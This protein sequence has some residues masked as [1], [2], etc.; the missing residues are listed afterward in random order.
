M[1]TLIAYKWTCMFW[2]GVNHRAHVAWEDMSWQQFQGEVGRSW[3]VLEINGGS[4][5][6]SG[7]DIIL[8]I[9]IEKPDA[10]GQMSF[11]FFFLCGRPLWSLMSWLVL[12]SFL[13]WLFAFN[14]LTGYKQT[15]GMAGVSANTQPH[16]SSVSVCPSVTA[17]IRVSQEVTTSVYC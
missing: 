16:C 15:Y 2:S 10:L 1:M 3:L 12:A 5:S 6:G 8:C 11:F 4:C 9:V 7:K 17:L 13:L 14:L